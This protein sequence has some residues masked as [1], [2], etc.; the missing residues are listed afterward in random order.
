[1]C[2]F[3]LR[4]FTPCCHSRFTSKMHDAGNVRPGM[5]MRRECVG[6]P[7][8][9]EQTV[10]PYQGAGEAAAGGVE[11]RRARLAGIVVPMGARGG[12]GE[13]RF[14]IS[15]SH[16]ASHWMR[17]E[18][19]RTVRVH[20]SSGFPSFPFPLTLSCL[21]PPNNPTLPM[22]VSRNCSS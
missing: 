3:T 13:A 6:T 9:Y 10:R 4:L 16:T 7:V 2:S 17:T 15:R 11:L 5:R 14:S 19:K 21:G 20:R 1:M 12:A 18:L 22:D 8:H